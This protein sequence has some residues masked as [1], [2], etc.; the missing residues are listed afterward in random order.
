MQESSIL[1]THEQLQHLWE[2]NKGQYE[3]VLG[4]AASPSN[5]TYTMS[6]VRWLVTGIALLLALASQFMRHLCLADNHKHGGVCTL[7][8]PAVLMCIHCWQLLHMPGGQP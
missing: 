6:L 4:P 7:A 8:L 2:Q 1:T 3:A 5:L